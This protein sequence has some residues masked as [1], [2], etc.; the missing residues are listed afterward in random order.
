MGEES[1]IE[2]VS[3]RVEAIGEVPVITLDE[4]PFAGS[5]PS[6]ALKARRKVYLPEKGG[7]EEVNIY[8]GERLKHGNVLNEVAIIETEGSTV[9]V[10]ENERLLVNKYGDF[11]IEIGR[12]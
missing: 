5:D 4:L 3:C 6:G 10:W 8:D 7:F 1:D 9:C 11:E 2:F 12:C